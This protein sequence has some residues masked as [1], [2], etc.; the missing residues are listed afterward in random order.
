MAKLTKSKF[1]NDFRANKPKEE[2]QQQRRSAWLKVWKWIK[3]ILVVFFAGI[4]VLGCVQSFTTKTGTKVGTGTEFY[5]TTK[6]VSPNVETFRYDSKSETFNLV[7]TASHVKDNPY[8]GLNN[9]NENLINDLKEQDK[10]T[11]ASYGVYNGSS[12]GIK[13]DKTLKKE[14]NGKTIEY[15]STIGTE[16]YSSNKRYLYYNLSKDNGTKV[17]NPVN[18]FSEY[19]LISPSYLSQEVVSDKGEKSTITR[20]DL[21]KE[22]SEDKLTN[23][24]DFGSSP[25]EFFARDILETLMKKTYE[26]WFNRNVQN[27]NWLLDPSKEDKDKKLKSIDG[28]FPPLPE[29]ATF[30]QKM[31]RLDELH[32]FFL[33]SNINKNIGENKHLFPTDPFWTKTFSEYGN[34][35]FNELTP[36]QQSLVLKKWDKYKWITKANELFSAEQIMFAKYSSMLNYKKTYKGIDKINHFKKSEYYLSFLTAGGNYN[37]FQPLSNLLYGNNN[38]NQ[39]ALVTQKDY[40]GQGPFFGMFVQ[41]INWFMHKIISGLN[42]TGWSIILA[43]VV[44]VIIVRFIAMLISFKSLFSQQKMEEVNKKKAK[45]EAKYAEYKNDKQMQQKKQ[46][47]IAELYR[48]EK[49]SPFSSFASMFI[50]LPILIVVYR[51]ISS[52]PEIKQATWYGIQFS[53]SSFRRLFKGEW[54]YLPLIFFSLGIQALAQYLPKLLNIKKKKSLRADAYE[55]EAIKKSNKRSNMIQL[56]FIGMGAF[57]SAGLQIYWI[58]GGIWTIFQNLFVHYFSKTKIFKEKIEPKLFKTA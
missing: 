14:E 5:T 4:G 42:T 56:I 47:E 32:K 21:L 20:Y 46:T 48:Q 1:Y 41:P 54:K 50:T 35:T 58:I 31:Q 51:I 52:S 23:K 10:N 7:N 30:E 11:G 3:I 37:S 9:K 39:K 27:I 24:V 49:I 25:V 57:F 26:E 16:V 22:I 6:K 15:H 29:N 40:W 44:T 17:Y 28:I 19:N 53:S 43:L 45:I 55:Q 18:K 33:K 38:I 12:L 13:L 8:L 2:L 34:K 36:Y